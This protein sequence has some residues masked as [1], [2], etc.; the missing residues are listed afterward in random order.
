MK[1]IMALWRLSGVPARDEWLR[2]PVFGN[3]SRTEE[4]RRLSIGDLQ[5]WRRSRMRTRVRKFGAD[6]VGRL[7]GVQRLDI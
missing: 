7:D 4:D 5:Q 1:I 2:M 6:D 3:P